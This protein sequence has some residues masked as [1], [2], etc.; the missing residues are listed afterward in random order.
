[1][2][3][4]NAS[5]FP[6]L[7]ARPIFTLRISQPPSNIYTLLYFVVN[8]GGLLFFLRDN[9]FYYVYYIYIHANG[10]YIKPRSL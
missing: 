4:R 9:R 8:L 2:G 6:D 3:R 10:Q 7:E 1:M 5:L